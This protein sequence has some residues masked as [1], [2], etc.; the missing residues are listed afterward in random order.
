MNNILVFGATS[1]IAIE[2]CKNFDLSQSNFILVG[3]DLEKLNTI[4]QNLRALNA[5]ILDQISLDLSKIE[6]HDALFS[7]IKSLMP[8]IDII[9][10]SYGILP[11]QNLCQ[12]HFKQELENFNV[13]FL[14]VC[15]ILN[16]YANYLEHF[17]KGTIVVITSVA[18][19]RGR[20]SNYSYGAAKGALSIYLEGIR[21]RLHRSNI[22]V[23]DIKP[24]F[25]DTSMTRELK[26]N[27]LF[28]S[29][30]KAGEIIF[31]K[32][33]KGLNGTVYVP[34]YWRWIMFV[35]KVIPEFIFNRLKL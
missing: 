34:F 27:F 29:S 17:K 32:I 2:V 21:S 30:Q 20:Q 6:T 4:S 7:K 31:S 16:Y 35:I 33:R 10:I 26:K 14:S 28:T 23:L 22:K 9:L 24:G 5:N 1:G 13:N 25:I 18:G 11:K 8:K 3:R 12:K 15:S 19:D